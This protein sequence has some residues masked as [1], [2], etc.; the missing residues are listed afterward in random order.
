MLQQATD[1]D[2]QER[3][4]DQQLESAN[5][6]QQQQMEPELGSGSLELRILLLGKHGVGKSATGNSIL[7][8][9]VFES[10]YSDEPVTKTCKK[11]SETVGKREVVVID[12]PDIFSTRI[13][14]REREQE[15]RRCITLCSP[16]PHILLLVTSLNFTTVEDEEVVKGIQNIF[17]VEAM[18]YMMFLFT[19]TEELGGDSLLEYIKETDNE[20]LKKLVLNP[21]V[22]YCGFNNKAGVAEQ[23][24]Q[25]GNL[26]EQ[27]EW[28]MQKNGQSYA[29]FNANIGIKE[30]TI[31]SKADV[32]PRLPNAQ[33]CQGL[34]NI[35]KTYR[36]EDNASGPVVPRELRLIL[37]G[38]TGSGKSATGNSI[39]G[40]KVFKSKLSSRPVTESCQRESRE[41]H[42][43]TLVVID[44]P[45]IFSSS[46]KTKRDL[47]ICRCM[48]LSSPGPH[49]LLLVMQ[50]GRY[51]NEDKEAL[52]S[53]QEI[54]GVGILSHTI[55]V[56][57]RKEDLGKETLKE[58]LKETKNK[59]LRWLNEVCEGF[60]CG[61]NNK[62]E[63][64]GQEA[65]LK[66]MM[67]MIEGVVRKNDL[68][69]YSSEV[70]DYIQ[71]NIQQLREELGEEPIGQG[72]GPKGAFCKENIASKEAD[73]TC[74]ALESLMVIQRK[75]EQHQESVLKKESGT[76]WVIGNAYWGAFRRSFPVRFLFSLFLSLLSAMG[77]LTGLRHMIGRMEARARSLKVPTAN[78]SSA[79]D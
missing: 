25:V 19:R 26:L 66:E 67:E 76:P 15:V 38:K 46:A 37:V 13:C 72:E 78:P 40:K 69:C 5:K 54:F 27:I 35:G 23:D 42:G 10:K 31:D 20:H 32:L 8:K 9:R 47:E 61:F 73:Q 75:Y 16:G 65:Q 1:M 56:F 18:R 30:N 68:R 74:S 62:L 50:L 44:T 14:A 58:Y 45:D 22:Q 12:T 77:W 39:L 55:I 60:H 34:V 3:L 41:W 17:G 36:K 51:T 52:R 11:E 21:G 79:T 28:L 71:E 53:I 6:S 64:E 43:R 63:G 29:H 59:S 4:H 7:G 49:A 48:V 33:E 2:H 70:Y 57:T 24:T